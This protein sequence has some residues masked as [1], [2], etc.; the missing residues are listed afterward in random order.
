MSK[1]FFEIFPTMLGISHVEEIHGQNTPILGV[2]SSAVDKRIE[3]VKKYL[4]L[5]EKVG[6][7][8]GM[9]PITILA[10]AAIE[11]GW[12]T[13]KLAKENNNFFGFTAYGKTNQYWTGAKRVSTSSGLPFRSYTNPENGFRDFARLIKEKYSPA[14]KASNDVAKYAT[15]ISHSPYINEKNGDNRAK[16]NQLIIA[17][18]KAIIQIAGKLLSLWN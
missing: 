3:Y 7:E 16:Y 15:L 8:F 13:S 10:Q 6:M 12:G 5:A 17:N 2:A 1:E 14:F 4:K 9:N 11:S 18:A